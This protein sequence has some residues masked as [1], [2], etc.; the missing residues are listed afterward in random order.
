MRNYYDLTIPFQSLLQM[1][2]F[3]EVCVGGCIFFSMIHRKKTPSKFIVLLGM[4]VSGSMLVLYTAEARADLRNLVI[5]KISDWLCSK[6]AG[7]PVMVFC[8]IL[9]VYSYCVKKEMEFRKNTITRSSIKEG[10]DKISSGLCF[11]MD[12]GRLILANR[13][14]NELSFAITGQDLQNAEVFWKIL[15]EGEIQPEIQRLSYGNRPNFRLLDGTVWTFAYENLNDIHQLS[16][17]DTTQI[18]LVTDELREKNKEL[19]TLNLRLRKHGEN[20][21]ELTR[22]RERLETKV[23]IHSELGQAL[24]S[25]R[26]FLMDDENVQVPPLEVWQQN[27]AILRKEAEYKEDEQSLEML[28][29]IAEST[30]IEIDITGEF[31]EDRE[32]QKFLV[33]VA[34]E[35]LTNAIS[36]ANAQTLYM[37]LCSREYD[38]M[39]SFKNDGERPKKEITEG[40]G[41]SSLRKKVEGE[42]GTLTVRSLPEFEMIVTLPKRKGGFYDSGITC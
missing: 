1:C 40:G 32:I 11:Y 2:L 38:Y 7:I 12:G 15:S 24:L 14:M 6:P 17:A 35:A 41:L 26:R 39:V 34:A 29:R 10:I 20:V 36:H 13:R 42:G 23:R 31:P 8:V 27:I 4:V 3:L 22:S 19:E 28:R 25:T 33:Q 9:A 21:D 5:P 16:A 30:G 18:Q 37:E